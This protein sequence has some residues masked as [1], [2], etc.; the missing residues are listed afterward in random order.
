VYVSKAENIVKH[1]KV[2]A[3]E[4]PTPLKILKI[5]LFFSKVSI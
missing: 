2:K 4:I 3:I 1:I 5:T